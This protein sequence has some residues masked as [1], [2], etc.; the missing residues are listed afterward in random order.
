MH[1]TYLTLKSRLAEINDLDKASKLLGWDQRTMMPKQGG[2]VRA[3]QNATLA[4]L[5]HQLGTDP[6]LGRLLEALRPYEESLPYDSDEASL[7]RFARREF[8]KATRVPTDLRM[9]MARAASN[10]SDIWIQA[11]KQSDFALFL[12][13]LEENI[14]LKHRYIECFPEY[15]DDPNGSVYDPLLDDFEPGMKTV[16]VRRIF[17]ELKRDL[18]PLI[19]DLS[20]RLHDVDTS[21]LHGSFPQETQRQFVL[22]ILERFGFHTDSWR[23]DPTTHPF[24]SSMGPTDIRLT[25]RY[26]E[27]FLNPCL[28]GSMH[29]CGHGLYENGVSQDLERTPLCRGVSS[30]LH[31]SQSRMWENLVGRSRPFWTFFYPR[32]QA[33]FPARFDRVPLDA[34][35]RAINKVHPSYI[36][37]EADEVTYAM[38][39]I[40]RF[41]LEQEIFEGRLAPRD[42]PETWQTRFKDYLGLDLPEDSQGVLQDIHWSSGLFGYFPTYQLGNIAASQIWDAVLADL[43][44]L[45]EQFAR[46]EFTPLRE[47]LRQRLHRHGKKFTPLET[48]AKALDPAAAG[49]AEIQ[50]EPY[51]R[52]IR[53]KFS[54]M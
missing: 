43:P 16:D 53:E 48:L 45:Y 37:V 29:E 15:K 49:P 19:R 35:Y 27:D 26:Y 39:I 25:T 14:E 4:K 31:E 34:F 38:H 42:L 8:D 33:A 13:A 50:V 11:R 47:W 54:E 9:A 44:D 1:E 17:D 18:V 46:G 23:L 30:T 21:M 22:G 5:I 12:P 28:F 24:A 20:D 7:I 6:E 41:E 10:G 36:R 52:Y 40:L 3:E 51:I 32:L 2:R